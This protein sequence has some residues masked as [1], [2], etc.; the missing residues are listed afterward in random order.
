MIVIIGAG[1]AGLYC[2]DRLLDLKQGISVTL[3]EKNNRIGGRIYTNHE[4]GYEIGAGRIHQ[5]HQRVAKLI[6]RFN[7][8]TYPINGNVSGEKV[9]MFNRY[10][11]D[12]VKHLKKLPKKFLKQHVLAELIPEKMH[13]LF[14]GFPYWAE[15]FLLRADI[16]IHSFQHEMESYENYYGISGGIDQLTDSLADAV[17]KKGGKIIKNFE[18]TDIKKDDDFF[19]VTGKANGTNAFQATKVIIATCRCNLGRFSILKNKTALKY[20]RTSPLTRIYA[21]YPPNK[22]NVWFNDMN[23]TVVDSPLR[24]VIPINKATGLIMISYTDGKKDTEYWEQLSEKSLSKKISELVKKEFNKKLPE[25]TYIKKH[26]WS[27]GC[28]Y[29]IPGNYSIAKA[30]F[31]AKNLFIIGESVSYQQAWI[32]GALESVDRLFITGKLGL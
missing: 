6:K 27:G 29:W 12:T 13:H 23:P 5:S 10:M 25:P 32:E 9:E 7:L 2:A 21:I 22:G 18:V 3:L 24:F 26:H 28:T 19:T 31:P 4:I 14:S 15:L 20:L 1:I 30:M 11:N 16:A 17:I 8:H